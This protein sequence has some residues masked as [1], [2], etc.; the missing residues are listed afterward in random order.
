MPPPI[1]DAP[2]L[3]NAAATRQAMLDAARRHFARDSYESVGLRE[4]A[5]DAG[6]DPALVSRYFGSKEQLFQEALRGDKKKMLEGIAR[7]DLPEYLAGLIMD[8]GA[9]CEITAA[10]LDRVMILLR[11]ATS[12]KA[13]QIVRAAIDED[14]LGPIARAIGG[15][16]AEM[17]AVLCMAIL[18]GDGTVRSALALNAR[19]DGNPEVFRARLIRL[20][21]AALED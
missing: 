16:D 13:S 21:K 5:G 3:R 12:P 18:M 15:E 10:N 7:D 8:E 20:F 4:I 9:S 1:P 17:R 2:R 6:V 11:S 14:M 19:C